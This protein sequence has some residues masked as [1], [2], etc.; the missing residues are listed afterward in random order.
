MRS[1]NGTF[2]MQLAVQWVL[3]LADGHHT[4]LDMVERSGLPYRQLMAAAK[5]ARK[6]DLIVAAV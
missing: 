2:S 3:N 6:V 4:L 5:A 1:P